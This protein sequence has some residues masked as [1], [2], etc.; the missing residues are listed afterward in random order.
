MESELIIQYVRHNW[1]VLL[2][3]IC[4]TSYFVYSFVKDYVQ[5]ARL[6]KRK[7]EFEKELGELNVRYEKQVK[8]LEGKMKEKEKFIKKGRG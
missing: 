7:K 4:M 2:F 3:I 1:W 8:E 5:R 6:I